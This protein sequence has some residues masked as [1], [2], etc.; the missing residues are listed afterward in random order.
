[1]T[2]NSISLTS[3]NS[4]QRREVKL[5]E[6][7]LDR[8]RH[9]YPD[10]QCELQYENPFQ[11]L[12][13]TILSTQSTEA[14]VNVVTPELFDQFPTP[15]DFA[16]AHRAQIEQIIRPVGFYRQK[17][18]FVQETSR[19]LVDLYDS[20]VPA[21][22]AT[23]IQLPGVARKTAN[24]VL[25]EIYEIAEGISVDTHVHRVSNRLELST[26]KNATKVE[27]DL[28]KISDQDDWIELSYLF[29]E[30]GQKVC[31]VRRPNCRACP[32]KDLCPSVQNLVEA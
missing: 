2:V 10:A 14:K 31:H 20:H 26:G 15:S 30:H 12:I 28:M 32:L 23:L 13:A 18:K 21:D 29:I 16:D 8:L 7:I 3:A 19:I 11:L 6:Q 24:T 4:S 9:T 22:L 25:A 27:N 1:M 5:I 17:A